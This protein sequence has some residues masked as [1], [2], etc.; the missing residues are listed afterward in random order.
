MLSERDDDDNYDESCDY[1]SYFARK[2]A[3]RKKLTPFV[4]FLKVVAGVFLCLMFKLF[5]RKPPPVA[6]PQYQ[7]LYYY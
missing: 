6:K 3:P 5:F 4:S 2:R 1:V 7:P